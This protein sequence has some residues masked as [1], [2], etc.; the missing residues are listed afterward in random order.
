MSD[1]YEDHREDISGAIGAAILIGIGGLLGYA[2]ALWDI[3][4]LK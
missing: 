2:K 1:W 3:T 4:H